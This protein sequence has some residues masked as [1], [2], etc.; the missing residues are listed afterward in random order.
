[1]VGGEGW[2]NGEKIFFCFLELL[3]AL[4]AGADLVLW[5][6]HRKV[7]DSGPGL[8]GANLSLEVWVHL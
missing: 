6:I 8:G 1:M 2:G 4:K 7:P 5:L 3:S